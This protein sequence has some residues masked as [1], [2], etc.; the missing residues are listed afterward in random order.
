MGSGFCIMRG[1]TVPSTWGLESEH[2]AV[3]ERIRPQDFCSSFC[4]GRENGHRRLWSVL[5]WSLCLD[6][7]WKNSSNVL[8]LQ[9]SV[10]ITKLPLANPP[11]FQ[12][13]ASAIHNRNNFTPSFTLP[14]AG[15]VCVNGLMG[16]IDCIA[17]SISIAHQHVTVAW[18]FVHSRH[19]SVICD[20]I[21]GV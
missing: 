11:R 15:T 1:E 7:I 8:G 3:E 18:T 12:F 14:R 19:T 2:E 9:S 21:T 6:P 20:R 17:D 5:R 16:I 13:T 10:N 4:N